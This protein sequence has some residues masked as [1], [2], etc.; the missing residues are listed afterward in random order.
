M[1]NPLTLRTESSLGAVFISLLSL[2]FIGLI[3]ISI[4]NF[5]SD[6]DIMNGTYNNNPRVVRV[7]QT[8]LILIQSWVQDNNIVIPDGSGYK[9]LLRKYPSKPWLN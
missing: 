1:K 3:F 6:I 2:F 9:Y 5:N 4:K 8:E 7:S